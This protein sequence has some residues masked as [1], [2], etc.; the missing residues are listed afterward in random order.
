MMADTDR[1]LTRIGALMRQAEGTDNPHE[2]EAFLSRP[3][4]LATQ[5]SID[6]TVA[7]TTAVPDRCR[8]CG[9]SR[10]ARKEPRGRPRM[11]S[12]SWSARRPNG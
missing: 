6:L 12:C 7:R 4:Q 3:Q 5:H 1:L 10:S 8:G 11:C 9:A 2:A